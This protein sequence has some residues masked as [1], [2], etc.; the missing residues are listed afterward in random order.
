MNNNI[1]RTEKVKS[2]QKITQAAEHN[3]WIRTQLNID[4]SRSDLNV[5]Y[6]NSLNA[7]T[8]NSSSLQ[9]KLTEYYQS[10]GIKEKKDNVLMMEF[11]VS[12]S[13]EFFKVKSKEEI[14]KWAKH[15]VEFFKKEFGEQVKIAVLHLDEKTPHLHFMVGTEFESVKKYKNQKGEFFKKTWSLNA[16]RY[17]P[18]YLVGLHDRHAIW[19]KKFGLK[20]GVKGSMRKHKT[21]KEF[22][23]IVDKSLNADYSKSIEKVIE[24]LET[25]FLSN[26]VSIE[27]VREKFKPMLNTL[28]KQN[29]VL[30]DKF[31]LDIKKWANDLSNLEE[32]LEKKQEELS[33]RRE[34][35]SDAINRMNVD[36]KVIKEIQD[37]NTALK[38]ELAKYKPANKLEP[39]SVSSINKGNKLWVLTILVLK[40]YNNK[41]HLGYKWLL[42][43]DYATSKDHTKIIVSILNVVFR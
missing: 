24:S 22:Y 7:D 29:K 33:A 28:L 2:R 21:L 31:A 32:D 14:E 43:T 23:D 26:K 35:Y 19:N 25:S 39:V 12:A 27:E 8:K 30:K 1:L 11:V 3:F 36:A 10:L 6:I 4:G 17:D 34:V 42:F 40:A 13:P 18:E 20:R 5:I 38:K 9:E 37:E 16:K 15:Q 41:S